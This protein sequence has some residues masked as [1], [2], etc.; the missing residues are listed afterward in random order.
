MNPD[1]SS[2]AVEIA[3]RIAAYVIETKEPPDYD[4]NSLPRDRSLIELGILDSY[5]VIELV[6]FLEE[7]WSVQILD[8]DL[9]K[10]RMGSIAKMAQLVTQKLASR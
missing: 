9:T 8:E 1:L 3:D 4:L 10:E 6:E 2:A 7:T 5:G